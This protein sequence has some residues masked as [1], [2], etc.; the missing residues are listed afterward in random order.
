MIYQFLLFVNRNSRYYSALSSINA[1][2]NLKIE[3]II[4][5]EKCPFLLANNVK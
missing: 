1:A 4:A 3:G 2:A 5:E